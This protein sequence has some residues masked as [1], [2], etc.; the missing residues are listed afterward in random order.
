ML[1]GL[2]LPATAELARATTIPVIASGGLASIEDVKQLLRPEYRMLEGAI[3][4]RA[5]Y[6]GR[7]GGRGAG[8]PARRRTRLGAAA[9]VGRSAR[10]PR[11]FVV[12]LHAGDPILEHAVEAVDLVA[13]RLDR[14][15]VADLGELAA[16]GGMALL[17]TVPVR[18]HAVA[19]DAVGRELR[20]LL[21]MSCPSCSILRWASS[22]VGDTIA[23]TPP[24]RSH[25]GGHPRQRDSA[26][27]L[28]Q[29]VPV[30]EQ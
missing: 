25:A 28:R 27:R 26:P 29:E 11:L 4:G 17:E 2:N 3:T 8:A 13:Q 23:R 22:N 7:L 9:S 12:A 5:L 14:A 16:Q 30:C 15:R 24:I 10:A 20:F 21:L 18:G 1:K 19:D 6:D